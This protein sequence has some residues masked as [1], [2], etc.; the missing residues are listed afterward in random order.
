MD[1]KYSVIVTLSPLP[2]AVTA[3]WLKNTMTDSRIP[4]EVISRLEEAKN[5]EQ[6][7]MRICVE[8]MHEV[9][10]IPG[11]SGV[12][13]MTTGDP[14]AITTTIQASGMGN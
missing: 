13:L 3:K 6:E 2:S 9:S 5:P 14:E 1:R 7:G 12:N 10:E 8:L 11:V 4:A